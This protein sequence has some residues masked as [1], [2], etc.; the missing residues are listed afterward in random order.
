MIDNNG[1]RFIASPTNKKRWAESYETNVLP[2][3][4][5]TIDPTD[6]DNRDNSGNISDTKSIFYEQERISEALINEASS[7]HIDLKSF[8]IT[9]AAYDKNGK[10]I[11][12]FKH[13]VL[14]KAKSQN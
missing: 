9:L 13:F 12:C 1:S 7:S 2:D 8:K 11:Y 5:K 10:K 3:L 6:M 14:M 4:S